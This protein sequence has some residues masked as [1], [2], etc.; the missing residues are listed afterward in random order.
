MVSIFPVLQSKAT[1]TIKAQGHLFIAQLNNGGHA[2]M[3]Y[4]ASNNP[5]K[6][7]FLLSLPSIDTK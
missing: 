3:D 6:Q 1:D 7:H 2:H 5:L 4:G